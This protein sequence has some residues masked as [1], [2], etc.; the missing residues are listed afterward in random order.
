MC[1][2]FFLKPDMAELMAVFDALAEPD[3]ADAGPR[4]NIAPTQSVVACR[5]DPF[6]QRELASF[7][8]GLV[9]SWWRET[10]LPVF[11][12]ARSE[13]AAQKPS[14]RE[15]FRATR[16]L[17]PAS[18]YYEWQGQGKTKVPHAIGLPGGG[19]L[20]M[21]GLWT[22]WSRGPEPVASVALLTTSPSPALAAIHDR[23]PV[24]LSP[25]DWSAWLDPKT[26]AAA[27]QALCVPF[28]R[29]LEARV[30]GQ[31]VGNVRDSSGSWFGG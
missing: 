28:D 7:R 12:N 26:P 25:A 24:V 20:G 21:A 3:A 2:R 31:A 15:A 27:V 1:A 22:T 16:C 9:P 18:G 13:E 19:P 6:G 23:M 14:F 8:W 10:K 29:P 5:L 30:V 17:V 4:W 11:V